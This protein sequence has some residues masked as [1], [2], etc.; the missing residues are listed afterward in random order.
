MESAYVHCV[1]LGPSLG[2]VAPIA[3]V[4]SPNAYLLTHLLTYLLTY[5]LTFAWARCTDRKGPLPQ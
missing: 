5:L 4:R 1:S 2:H 3:R